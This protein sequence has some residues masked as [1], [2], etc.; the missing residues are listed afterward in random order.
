MKPAGR[1]IQVDR[2]GVHAELRAIDYK[3]L[4][5]VKQY[6]GRATAGQ[7]RDS[8][9]EKISNARCAFLLIEFTSKKE[10]DIFV[11]RRK[12]SSP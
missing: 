7:F 5:L 12:G 1:A 4:D 8:L 3:L 10:S 11:N 2:I 6:D 9:C